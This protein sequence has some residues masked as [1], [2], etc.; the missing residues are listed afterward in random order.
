VIKNT[1]IFD[2][3]SLLPLNQGSIMCYTYFGNT[4]LFT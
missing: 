4:G 1:Y 2:K 3:N